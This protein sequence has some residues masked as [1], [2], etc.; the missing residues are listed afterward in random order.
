[1]ENSNWTRPH[2]EKEK[3]QTEGAERQMRQGEREREAIEREEDNIYKDM[4]FSVFV[5]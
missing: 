2:R 3:T 4:M 1:M 5:N